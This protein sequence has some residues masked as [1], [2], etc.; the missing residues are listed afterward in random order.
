MNISRSFLRRIGVHADLLFLVQVSVKYRSL[1]FSAEKKYHINIK[2][3]FVVINPIIKYLETFSVQ[4][5]VHF[6][7]QGNFIIYTLPENY[8]I[9]VFHKIPSRYV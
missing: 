3:K 9:Y 1:I 6:N 8:V 5:I 4:N 7:L 2:K